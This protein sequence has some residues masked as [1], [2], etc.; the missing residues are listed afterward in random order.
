MPLKGLTKWPSAS[1]I[2]DKSSHSQKLSFAEKLAKP[3]KVFVT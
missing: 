3:R 1:A 2:N